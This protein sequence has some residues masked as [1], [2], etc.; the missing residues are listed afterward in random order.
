MCNESSPCI[1]LSARFLLNF[2]KDRYPAEKGGKP[3]FAGELLV[4][5]ETLPALCCPECSLGS[6]GAC[7]LKAETYMLKQTTRMCEDGC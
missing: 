2:S 1:I 4:R 3:Y 6:P 7:M 5:S